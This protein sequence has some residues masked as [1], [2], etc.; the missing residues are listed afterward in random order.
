M[1]GVGPLAKI[2][3]FL[4]ADYPDGIPST[5]HVP[6]VA[7]LRRRLCDDDLERIAEEI[8]ELGPPV[9]HHHV[10]VAVRRVLREAACAGDVDEVGRRLADAGWLIVDSS[11]RVADG[12]PTVTV[13]DEVCAAAVDLIPGADLADVMLARDDDVISVAATSE[14]C[15]RLCDLRRDA[16]EGPCTHTATDTGVVRTADLGAD[17]RWTRFAPAAVELGVRSCLSFT[18]YRRPP[19]IATLNVFGFGANAWD[20]DAEA[21]G[22]ALAAHAAATICASVWGSRM[23]SPLGD[24]E[25]ISQAKG[26]VMARHGIDDVG[27]FEVLRRLAAEDGVGLVDMARRVI[28]TASVG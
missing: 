5:G 17:G 7:L 10:D 12:S 4:R 23:T 22:A 24:S 20:E 27:A 11:G 26:I 13:F 25:R 8:C 3:E 9:R 6:L 2:V 19:I 28:G 21:I 1:T 16:G 18:L 15:A 14:L